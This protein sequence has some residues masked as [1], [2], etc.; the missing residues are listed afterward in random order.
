MYRRWLYCVPFVATINYFTAHLEYLQTHDWLPKQGNVVVVELTKSTFLP[1]EQRPARSDS[2]ASEMTSVIV[3][4]R[5]CSEYLFGSAF[6]GHH[7]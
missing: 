6:G 7:S 4:R 3:L 2:L 1:S 5:S